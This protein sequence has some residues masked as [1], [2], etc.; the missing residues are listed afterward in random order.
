MVQHPFAFYSL[1]AIV[2]LIFGAID[3]VGMAL[4]SVI[5]A[6]T[7]SVAYLLG[8]ELYNR[9]AGIAAG[10]LLITSPIHWFISTRVLND[11]PLTFFML[12][13]S[14]LFVKSE[15]SDSPKL[16]YSAAIVAGIAALT[17]LPGLLL[18]PIFALYAL[19]SRGWAAFR[20]RR[21]WIG[22][23]AFLALFSLWEVRNIFFLGHS[24]VWEVLNTY[25]LSGG[26]SGVLGRNKNPLY[27]I[28]NMHSLLGI[29]FLLLFVVGIVGSYVQERQESI[30]PAIYL[31]VVLLI[32]SIKSSNLLR[33]MLPFVPVASVMAGYGAER[34]ANIARVL[35][36]ERAFRAALAILIVVSVGLMYPGAA[37]N[38]QGSAQGYSGLEDAG[39]WIRSQT[40]PGDAV[41]ASSDNQMAWYTNRD[42]VYK[43]YTLPNGSAADRFVKKNDVKYIEIDRW[44]VLLR[45]KAQYAY[46]YYSES[47][48]YQ[49]VNSFGNREEGA[50]V[51]VYRPIFD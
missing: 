44:E 5:G 21:Y 13:A 36:E 50:S 40:E 18:V 6:L 19:Y 41:V 16:F 27:Y 42:K 10:M 38:I 24:G 31:G 14:Y 22:A 17:K 3:T 23:G 1:L 8:E 9:Y 45:K 39:K 34:I 33:Y 47:P 32:F 26:G 28:L 11:A 51:I 48:N 25:L 46:T 12:L 4:V 43:A 49:A 35:V 2:F 15:R 30:F 29:P 20:M 37:A 7:A